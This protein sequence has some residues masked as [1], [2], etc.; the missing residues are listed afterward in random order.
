MLYRLDYWIWDWWSL[1]Y[2]LDKIAVFHVSTLELRREGG[3]AQVGL[4]DMVLVV[5]NVLIG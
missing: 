2:S 5:S 4:L 3:T 1:I